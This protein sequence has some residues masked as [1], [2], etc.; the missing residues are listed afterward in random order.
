MV[1][2]LWGHLLCGLVGNAAVVLSAVGKSQ[3]FEQI[4]SENNDTDWTKNRVEKGIRLVKNMWILA[5]MF[6]YKGMLIF[7]YVN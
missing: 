3:E 7:S 5:L 1:F 4:L 6:N 2:H